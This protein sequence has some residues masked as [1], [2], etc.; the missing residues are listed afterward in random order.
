MLTDNRGSESY[1]RVETEEDQRSVVILVLL[2]PHLPLSFP[3]FSPYRLFPLHAQLRKV[4]S[5]RFFD[6]RSR[7]SEMITL[8]RNSFLV[9]YCS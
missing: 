6:E 1:K 3:L 9:G 2:R 5:F 4:V 7:F 8:Q